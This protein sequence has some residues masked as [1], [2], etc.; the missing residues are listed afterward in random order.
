[1][2]DPSERQDRLWARWLTPV[3]QGDQCRLSERKGRLGS[4]EARLPDSLHSAR[5]N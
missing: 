1:M 2:E 4:P 5:F 3:T